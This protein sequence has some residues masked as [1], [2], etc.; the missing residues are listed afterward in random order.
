MTPGKTRHW[1]GSQRC[2]TPARSQGLSLKHP[3]R[4][5]SSLARRPPCPTLTR[6]LCKAQ[7]LSSDLPDG[8]GENKAN[9]C[10][11]RPGPLPLTP[12]TPAHCRSR[13]P[14]VLSPAEW[15]PPRPCGGERGRPRQ[16]TPPAV[17]GCPRPASNSCRPLPVLARGTP[18]LFPLR[19]WILPMGNALCLLEV[20]LGWAGVCFPVL[21]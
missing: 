12:W 4:Q 6:A 7:H 16:A 10:P 14:A 8:L 19:T 18:A 17:P 2:P 9:L 1:K 15:A 5:H 11:S 3:A 20:T 21:A 13:C